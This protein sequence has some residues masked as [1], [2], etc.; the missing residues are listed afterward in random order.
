MIPSIS[1]K[2]NGQSQEATEE[3][4]EGQPLPSRAVEF[5]PPAL[6]EETLPALPTSTASAI[7]ELAAESAP[8]KAGPSPAL[9]D[10]RTFYLTA[11]RPLLPGG[12]AS[13][14]ENLIPAALYPY[15]DLAG[16]RYDYPFCLPHSPGEEWAIPLRTVFDRLIEK[17]VPEGAEGESFRKNLLRLEERMKRLLESEGSGRL[18]DLWEAAANQILE[19]ARSQKQKEDLI[20]KQFAA[21]RNALNIDGT[22]LP[23]DSS[24]PERLLQATASRV[25][26]RKVEKIRRE[27]D[28]L[29]ARLQDI[30]DTEEARASRAY[31]PEILK[32][33]LAKDGED[34]VDVLALSALL[35]RS[36]PAQSLPQKRQRRIAE[37]LHTLE[38][39]RPFLAGENR[40]AKPK[41]PMVQP[42][43]LTDSA[44]IALETARRW[45]K[46]FVA[47]FKALRI[48][49]LEVK[50]RYH[51]DKHDAFFETFD[52]NLLTAEETGLFPP[53]LLSLS[54]NHLKAEDKSLLLDILA[55]DFPIKILLRVDDLGESPLA[56]DHQPAAN[57]WAAHLAR[58]ALN[59][60]HSYV[61]QSGISNPAALAG[62]FANGLHYQGPALFA[63]YTAAGA[64]RFSSLPAYLLSTAAS[65]SRAF[66]G[67]A[68]DPGKGADWAS[69]FS[70][71]LAGQAERLWPE[72]SF[73]YRNAEGQEKTVVLEFTFADFLAADRRFAQQFLP[74]PPGTEG[75]KMVP[76]GEY[77]R[78][79]KE[80]MADKTPFLWMVDEK[81]LLWRVVVSWKVVAAAQKVAA[82]WRNLQELA[83][84]SN[85]HLLRMMEAEQKQWQKETRPA[86]ETAAAP[87][88]PSPNLAELTREIAFRIIHGLI[89]IG[90]GE[91]L[92][93]QPVAATPIAPPPGEAAPVAAPAP[94]AAKAEALLVEE[95]YIDSPLC[96]SCNEC[97]NINNRMFAYNENKQAYIKDVNAG[98]FKQLVQAAEK[99]PVSIIHP[100]KPKNPNEPGLEALIKRAA[101]FNKL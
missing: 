94:E 97:I 95:P 6:P 39:L 99:C 28:D 10:L 44:K 26:G 49:R 64:E 76:L 48:A 77:F 84:I 37:S 42:D 45:Q 32:V 18:S 13:L 3:N 87:P 34:E 43:A 50:N 93:Q 30:L 79:S 90:R 101:K 54:A 40:A 66:P 5:F 78:L 61:L 12:A 23:C 9:A 91:P 56:E 24:T 89:A 82:N 11:A 98:T 63:V 73:S 53:V 31:S 81:G 86:P 75:E 59:S 35:A 20:V 27:V 33:S 51:E 71:S 85:S 2:T 57:F 38:S 17:T 72:M 47:F 67:F 62:G 1:L 74:V 52:L 22:L 88:A 15:R 21:A 55:A 46:T 8:P 36:R 7:K 69:R 80:E 14:P 60:N 4:P 58:M 29:I 68:Y 92:P 25:W 96:T 65:R 19:E 70:L 41:G 16:L 83:G 100:G